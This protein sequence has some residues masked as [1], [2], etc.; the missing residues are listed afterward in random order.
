[1]G[2]ISYHPVLNICEVNEALCKGCGN[3]TATC[4]NKAIEL[5]HFNN[6]ELMAEMEGLMFGPNEII[7][8]MK[9]QTV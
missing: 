8:R 4:P 2:A 6:D 9:E 3:C 1:M 5:K 7:N